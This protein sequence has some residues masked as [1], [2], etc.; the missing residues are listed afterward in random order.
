MNLVVNEYV[1]KGRRIREVTL[2]SGKDWGMGEQ[3]GL[4][5]SILSPGLLNFIVAWRTARNRFVLNRAKS[6]DCCECIDFWWVE[7]VVEM[8][9]RDY[10]ERRKEMP[11]R[12]EVGMIVHMLSQAVAGRGGSGS[13]ELFAE[14]KIVVSTIGFSV[15]IFYGVTKST[16]CGLP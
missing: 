10:A 3:N 16:N 4:L 13:V 15:L 8:V 5:S 7:M 2:E 14:S 6:Q 1:R 11:V 12:S 9:L